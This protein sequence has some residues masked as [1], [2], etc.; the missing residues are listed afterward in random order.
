MS[1]AAHWEFDYLN[2]V[3]WYLKVADK[4]DCCTDRAV[5]DHC[6]LNEDLLAFKTFSQSEDCSSCSHKAQ[7]S[8]Q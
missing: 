1:V 8:I 2:K 5:N 7:W 6:R 4:P 3:L